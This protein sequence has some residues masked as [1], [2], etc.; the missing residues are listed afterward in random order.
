[1]TSYNLV[2]GIHTSESRV[3]TTD[4][5]MDELGYEGVIM[6]D[7]VI[8]GSFLVNDPKYPAPDAAKVAAAGCS[9][10]MPGNRKEFKEITRGLANGTVTRQQLQKNAQRLLELTERLNG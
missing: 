6:T 3:L 1:M 5:L 7:W 4:F 2:N 10:F 9:L 8:G